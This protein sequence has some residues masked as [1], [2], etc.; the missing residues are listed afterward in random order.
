MSIP[1]EAMVWLKEEE[2][3]DLSTLGSLLQPGQTFVDCGANI[4]LWTLVAAS[5]VGDS[6]KVIA[7]EPNPQ[8]HAKLSRN[9]SSNHWDSSVQVFNAACAAKAAR[10]PFSCSPEHNI[11]QVQ[12]QPDEHTILVE[13]LTLDS[14]LGRQTVHGIKLDIEGYE[15]QALQGA[16]EILQRSSPWLCVEFNP[17][18]SR[19]KQ[20]DHWDVHQFLTTRGYECRIFNTICDG[21][22]PPPLSPDWT[23]S[24]YT[25]LF[26]ERK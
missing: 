6:G 21:P 23:F 20:L 22:P 5:L 10:L 24:S 7:F 3:S 16:Q 18:L 13:A 12:L 8:T 25:N 19:V 9:V 14:I 2:A 4:G 11:S 15:L 1:Y 17:L 26:Y